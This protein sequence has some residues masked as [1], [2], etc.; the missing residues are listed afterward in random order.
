M[1]NGQGLL[2]N[3]CL[4]LVDGHAERMVLIDVLPAY[5][6]QLE[7]TKPTMRKMSQ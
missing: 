6:D 4:T 5:S 7:P 3:A 1:E 2:V